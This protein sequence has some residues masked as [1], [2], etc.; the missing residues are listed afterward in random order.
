MAV[1]PSFHLAFAV[2]FGAASSIGLRADEQVAMKLAKIAPLTKIRSAAVLGGL[3]ERRERLEI[4][5]SEVKQ[6]V[7]KFNALGPVKPGSAAEKQRRRALEELAGAVKSCTQE[8]SLFNTEV[9]DEAVCGQIAQTEQDFFATNRQAWAQAMRTDVVNISEP[10]ARAVTEE[11]LEGLKQSGGKTALAKLPKTTADLAPGDILLM[12]PDATS[13]VSRLIPSADQHYRQIG[14]FFSDNTTPQQTEKHDIAH[15]VLYLRSVNG[16]RLYLDHQYDEGSRVLD[17][18]EFQARYSKRLGYV[19]IPQSE[20]D[21]EKLWTAA[22]AAALHSGPEDYGVRGYAQVCS[23]KDVAVV[24][25]ATDVR[26][27]SIYQMVGGRGRAIE[28]TP[29]NFFHEKL[30]HGYF[31][32]TTLKAP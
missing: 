20:V 19:A 17:E 32:V 1:K 26:L 16:K 9:E 29:S 7:E 30:K 3:T 8:V 25:L 4:M 24:V 12:K 23:E 10:R 11:I 13:T 27:N 15:T 18:R 14:A 22:R 6:K 5:R 21:G 2:L 28:I 31:T